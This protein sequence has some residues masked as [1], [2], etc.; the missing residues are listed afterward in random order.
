MLVTSLGFRTDLM[1][2][3]LAGS[4]IAEG[5]DHIVVRTPSNPGYWWGNFLLLKGPLQAGDAARVR[6]LFTTELPGTTTMAIGVDGTGNDPG[7]VA[8][9]GALGLEVSSD[10]VLTADSVEAPAGPPRGLIRPLT[11]D[12]DWL[13]LG[14][15]RDAWQGPPAEAADERFRALRLAEDRDLTEGGSVAWFG[16]RED[17]VLVSALG[18]VCDGSGIARY[19]N[20]E[21]HPDHRRRGH[22]RHLL[23]AAATHAARELAAHT[24]VIV[25]D[26]DYHAIALYR[27]AGFHDAEWMVRLQPAAR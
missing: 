4:S 18:I 11:T 6:E 13:E 2:R 1:V 27:S 16:A 25:A 20:V 23:H 8:E 9:V 24:F 12:A 26:P 5:D 10:V 22:A 21:T 19:Q 7:A 15:L 17:D 3:R 14:A